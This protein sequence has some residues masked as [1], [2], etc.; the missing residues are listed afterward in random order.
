[1]PRRWAAWS[2]SRPTWAAWTSGSWYA[3]ASSAQTSPTVAETSKQPGRPASSTTRRSHSGI[4]STWKIVLAK[5]KRTASI[6]GTGAASSGSG[7]K[8]NVGVSNSER[9]IS[10]LQSGSI[11]CVENRDLPGRRL[12]DGHLGG[13]QRRHRPAGQRVERGQVADV[14]PGLLAQQPAD[15]EQ[16]AVRLDGVAEPADGRVRGGH[17]GPEH[18]LHPALSRL[19]VGQRG[20]ARR[21]VG[22]QVA[23]QD[24][25]LPLPHVQPGQLVQLDG[26]EATGGDGDLQPVRLV[27]GRLE[28]DLVDREA[29][30]VQAADLPLDLVAV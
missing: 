20:R 22:A 10:I 25:S 9:M 11:V 18:L 21:L 19:G 12:G 16:V 3:S 17:P 13:R 5:S 28:L 6:G 4:S 1:M 29:E 24:P 8:L 2:V 23:E 27:A 15:L 7:G 30:I 14:V 26:M